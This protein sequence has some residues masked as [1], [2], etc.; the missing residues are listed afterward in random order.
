MEV[1]GYTRLMDMEGGVWLELLCLA[2]CALRINWIVWRVFIRRDVVDW[3]FGLH[4]R[5]GG[6]SGVWQL[7]GMVL[8]KA[9]GENKC[10]LVLF[11]WHLKSLIFLTMILYTVIFIT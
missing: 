11:E 1:L 5:G 8:Q 7:L 4:R 9:L 3:R 6:D 2:V 10:W